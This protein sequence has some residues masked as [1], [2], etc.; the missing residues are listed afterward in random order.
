MQLPFLIAKAEERPPTPRARI[1]RTG[2]IG[3][4]FNRFFWEV[5]IAQFFG[6]VKGDALLFY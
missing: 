1:A 3:P 2:P 4:D 5:F 6:Q